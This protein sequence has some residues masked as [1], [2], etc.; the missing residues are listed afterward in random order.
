MKGVLS[1][2]SGRL[3]GLST[4]T[5]ERSA[6]VPLGKTF[7]GYLLKTYDEGK[8][9][10]VFERDGKLYELG[11]SS[12][13]IVEGHAA[14]ASP[15]TLEEAATVVD[16]LRFE[17]LVEKSLEGQKKLAVNMARQMAKQAGSDVDPKDLEEY[18][19]KVMD[20]VLE[21]M[22]VPQLKKEL[23]EIYAKTF[24]KEELTALGDFYATPAGRATIE[25]QPAV[26]EQLQTA[27][28]PRLV[29]AGPKFQQLAVEFAQQQAK[30]KAPAGGKK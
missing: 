26:Q 24:S 13:K 14:V 16:Q 1:T 23:T 30:K 29:A 6:W 2:S 11:L 15:A 25:K 28:M 17:D 8:G 12:A 27:M 4:G 21:A 7:E 20:T 19:T 18:Q 3:F 22:D 5:G 10:L 9:L